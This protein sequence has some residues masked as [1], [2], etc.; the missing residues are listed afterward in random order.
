MASES[1][2]I[3]YPILIDK[4][5]NIQPPNIKPPNVKPP[6]IQSPNIQSITIIDNLPTEYEKA[7]NYYIDINDD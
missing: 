7:C 6:N 3:A 4:K 2:W 5:S 1:E